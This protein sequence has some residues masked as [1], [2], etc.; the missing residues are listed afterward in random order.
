MEG[1]GTVTLLVLSI[2]VAVVSCHVVKEQ[3]GAARN[4]ARL[5][6]QEDAKVPDY[7][8]KVVDP[9]TNIPCILANMK[10]HLLLSKTKGVGYVSEDVPDSI[11][12]LNSSCGPRISWLTL[13]WNTTAD[14]DKLESSSIKFTFYSDNGTSMLDVVDA[15]VYV[16]PN[17]ELD[18]VTRYTDVRSNLHEFVTNVSNG[19]YKCSTERKIAVSNKLVLSFTDISL[20]TFN[21]E[22]DY[23]KRT[24]VQCSD[25]GQDSSSTTTTTTPA[26]TPPAY[27]FNYVVHEKSG[28]GCILANMSVSVTISYETKSSKTE[29]GTIIVPQKGI[30]T[31]YC[32]KSNATM[33]ITWL[34]EKKP[35]TMA[36]TVKQNSVKLW[37][38][39]DD[40][41]YYV[42]AIDATIFMDETHFKDAKN[43]KETI[44]MENLNLFTTS[45]DCMNKCAPE[46]I[47]SGSK[48]EVKFT[49]VALIAFNA[50]E[51]IEGITEENCESSNAGAIV[52]GII[53]ALVAIALIAFL[54]VLWRRRSR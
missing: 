35:A 41:S 13:G 1:G 16:K 36:D 29:K 53:G 37:F 31:G 46:T 23:S 50:K 39:K 8:F 15:D 48:S 49:D 32:T 45:A 43:E 4:V 18:D 9:T 28:V 7:K 54:I 11:A 25:N 20:I 5:S 42:N 22:K 30:V 40:L 44:A 27:S 21:T 34:E 26:P 33:E 52:G 12:I 6:P 24:A 51:K 47:A 3:D 2:L 19:E 10:F 38:T 14:K 17:K